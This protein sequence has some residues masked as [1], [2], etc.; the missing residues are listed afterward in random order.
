MKSRITIEVDFDM[1]QP[2]LQINSV[3]S[4]DVRDK[5]LQSFIERLGH[6]SLFFYADQILFNK[7]ED[8]SISR[9]LRVYSVPDK[10]LDVLKEKIRVFE[11]FMNNSIPIKA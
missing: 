1:S 10:E 2:Y 9:S 11:G 4:D 7:N 3:T 6:N 8:G 5:I